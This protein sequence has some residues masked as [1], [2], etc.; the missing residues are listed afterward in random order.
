MWSD[1]SLLSVA[2]IWGINIPI[3]KIGLD[4]L[5]LYVFNAIRLA[6]SA[7]VLVAFSWKELR[8][9]FLPEGGI[10]W[11]QVLI[12]A[13]LA[14]GFYQ[15]LFLLGMARTTSGNTALIMATIPMWTALLAR[16][17]IG[18]TIQRLAWSGL[19]IA[20]VGTIIVAVQTGNISAGT[21]HLWGNLIILLAALVWSGGTVYS[22][23]LL[24]RTSPL[25]LSAV[26]SIVALPMHLVVAAGYYESSTAE[27]QSVSIWVILL[28]SGVLSSGL[29]LPLWNVGV[30]HAGAA[31]AAII[32]NLIPLIAIFAAWIS[33]GETATA[34]Q[35]VGG[36]L[37]LTGLVLM[38]VRR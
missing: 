38:R 27:L 17:F 2:V 14:S 6:I 4:H 10:T 3:M 26:A 12:Y 7:G 16:V 31:H 5:N 20:L 13:V 33:R 19:C 24:R 8:N 30:R 37:I 11:R 21:D 18:E 23:P 28:Y 34:A 9:G 25:H 1:L 29:A 35:L 22:R 32:Q 15:L 36:S